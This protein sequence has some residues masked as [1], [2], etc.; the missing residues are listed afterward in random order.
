MPGGACD[1]L[2]RAIAS[3]AGVVLSLPS[4][5]GPP[6]HRQSRFLSDIPAGFWV[7]APGGEEPPHLEALVASPQRI[8]VSFRSGFH[9]VFFAA[10]VMRVGTHRV[11]AAARVPALLLGFPAERDAVKRCLRKHV[12]VPAGTDLSVRV[13]RIGP[14]APLFP[15]PVPQLE[16]ECDLSDISAGGLGVL[17]R[18]R[19]AQPPVSADDRVR[20][21]LHHPGGTLLLEGRVRHLA[22]GVGCAG[23]GSAGV[24][25]KDNNPAPANA[26]RAGV[27][28]VTAPKEMDGGRTLNQLTRI[29]AALR[30]EELR[31]LRAGVCRV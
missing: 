18:G 27:E 2:L 28:F 19:F 8:G 23:A 26:V 16:L 10:P 5:D 3:N 17:F 7:A 12:R 13:W 4:G 22:R 20:V 6:R 9:K 30:R 29:V 11:G 21:E 31:A 24:S 15:R 25:D 1:I 14:R